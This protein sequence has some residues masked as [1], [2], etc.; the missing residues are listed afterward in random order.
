MASIDS[1]LA[2]SIKA[3]VLTTSTSASSARDVM[4]I[5]CCKTLP[6]MISASTRFLAQPRLIMPTFGFAGATLALFIFDFEKTSAPNAHVE[7]SGVERWALSVGRFLSGFLVDGHVLIVLLQLLSVLGEFSGV[8]RWA[9]SVGRFLSGFLV[10]G[11]V[12]IVLLQLLSVQD[13]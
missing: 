3:Q 13:V 8:E 12:L 9:L 6:S 10:D 1:S 5:P 7:F 4:S 2:E 11:H